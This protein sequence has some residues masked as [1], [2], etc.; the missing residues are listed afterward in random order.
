MNQEPVHSTPREETF[1][2][3]ALTYTLCFSSQ[4][5]Q[6]DHCLR[7]VLSRYASQEALTVKSVN[8]AH[9]DTQTQHCPM[10]RSDAPVRMPVGLC[11]V[12]HDMPRWMEKS[13]KNHLIDT[14]SRKRYYEYHNGVRPLTPD[15]EQR[16]RQTLK[17]FG[18][19]EEPHFQG[20][21]EEWL[22]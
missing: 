7:V 18:W 10:Y 11:A 9:P 2:E 15:V 22:W 17:D 20:Y 19:T 3:K 21:V 5:P 8:L 12:Y 6:R 16:V 13:V 1:R 4:C 14:Y